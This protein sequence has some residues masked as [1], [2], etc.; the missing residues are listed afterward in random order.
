MMLK[1]KR[2][3]LCTGLMLFSLLIATGSAFGEQVSE[4]ESL[5]GSGYWLANADTFKYSVDQSSLF[6]REQVLEESI[7]LAQ[8]EAVIA[9]TDFDSISINKRR[10][11]HVENDSNNN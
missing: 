6:T 8:K 9:G 5:M 2:I 3:L 4:R 1:N 10:R 11:Y 7:Y